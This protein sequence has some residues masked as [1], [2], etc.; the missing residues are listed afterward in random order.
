MFTVASLVN[1][2]ERIKRKMLFIY[3]RIFNICKK[4]IIYRDKIGYKSFLFVPPTKISGEPD[5]DLSSCL[6]HIIG[7]LRKGGFNVFYKHPSKILII[8]ECHE[9]YNILINNTKFLYNENKR[10]ENFYKNKNVK[11]LTNKKP[12]SDLPKLKYCGK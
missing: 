5:Y 10:T 7:K 11:L 6:C 1:N 4:E 2:E 8:W 9:K 12:V 3:E